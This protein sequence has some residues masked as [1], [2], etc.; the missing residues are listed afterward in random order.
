MVICKMKKVICVFLG[1]I[2][3]LSSGC[4]QKKVYN[5]SARDY[6][7]YNMEEFPKD[8]LMLNNSNIR[9]QDLSL[10]LFEGLVS[11]DAEGNI[12]PALASEWTVSKDKLTYAFTIR[13]NAKW[14]DGSKITSKDFTD[15]FSRALRE[16]N[17]IYSKQLECIFG[18]KDYSDK[19]IGFDG[20]AITAKNEKQLEIRLNYPCSYFLDIIASPALSLKENFYNLRQWKA[21]YKKIK[22]SGPFTIDNIYENGEIALKKNERYWDKESVLSN[23]IHIRNEK[24]D[25]FALASYKSNDID[26]LTNA[27][28]SELENMSS[29]EKMIKGPS[30]EG[31]SLNFN[32]NKNRVTADPYFRKAVNYAID[33]EGIEEQLNGILDK[34]SSY[35]PYNIKGIN[36]EENIENLGNQKESMKDTLSR[37]EYDGEK[38][39]LVYLD[40]N[41]SNKK[42]AN[43]IINNLKEV[44]IKVIGRGYSEEELKEVIYSNDYDM[45]LTNYIG[46]YDSPY[47]FLERWLSDSPHNISG[48]KNFQFDSYVLNSR[49]LDN[50]EEMIGKFKEAEKTLIED[51]PCIPIGF[52]NIT[53]CRKAYING[54]EVNKKGNVILKRAYIR[55]PK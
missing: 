39:S 6:I 11:V 32:L 45:L 54:M 46:E 38:V 35:I 20:V 53:L 21:E 28:S 33:K 18:A 30:A 13:E 37:S 7:V 4:I 17:N 47:A 23:K 3:S 8:L 9:Q 48:Y 5:E 15:F 1:I 29:D 22:Y 40:N 31:V 52:Y 27:P 26:I 50:S 41:D 55:N 44:E 51:M 36:R 16:E 10:A 25:A 2:M 34:A 14:S 24:T 49:M 43:S 42:I 19:R 12:I